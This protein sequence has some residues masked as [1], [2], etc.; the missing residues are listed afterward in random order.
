MGQVVQVWVMPGVAS[1]LLRARLVLIHDNILYNVCVFDKKK[2]LCVWKYL[3][4]GRLHHL[5]TVILMKQRPMKQQEFSTT[6]MVNLLHHVEKNI[7]K[8]TKNVS[9]YKA[10]PLLRMI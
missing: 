5:P 4:T 6:S 2:G 3:L 10:A 8:T 1:I 9:S 7:K